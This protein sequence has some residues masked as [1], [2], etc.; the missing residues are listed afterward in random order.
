M[1]VNW[2]QRC[3]DDFQLLPIPNKWMSGSLIKLSISD[4]DTWKRYHDYRSKYDSKPKGKWNS[5]SSLEL[6]NDTIKCRLNI[7]HCIISAR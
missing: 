6:I 1:S 2:R 5:H 3:I 7:F 4:D